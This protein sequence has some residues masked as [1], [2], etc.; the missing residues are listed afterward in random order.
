MFQ[1][2]RDT[3][4]IILAGFFITNAIVAEL[5]GGKLIVLGPWQTDLGG[6][7]LKLGPF[8]MSIG[9]LPWPVVFIITDL[10][11]EHFGKKGVRKLTF[12][13]TV[14][15]IY[16]FILLFAGM[17]IPAVDFSPVKDEQFSAVFGQSMWI[18]IGSVTAFVVSQLTDVMLFWFFKNLT[19]GKMIWLRATGSTVVSQLIDTF[20]VA[21][22]AFW[23]PGKITFSEYLNMASTGYAAKLIIAV[24]MTPLI[25]L[26][27]GVIKAYLKEK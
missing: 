2:R 19:H 21:G 6:Q 25:Y 9:I 1:S 14:L 8:A 15:I 20:I 16:A 22:I 17:N 18:I 11:N 3:V 12:I 24:A 27:H 5:I 4:F 26:G 13:T 10:I 7:T 23:L